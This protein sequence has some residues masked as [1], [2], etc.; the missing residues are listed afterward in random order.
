ETVLRGNK[1]PP[2]A[3]MFLI[4][5]YMLHQTFSKLFRDY[6][7]T[8]VV[9]T[10]DAFDRANGTELEEL[11]KIAIANSGQAAPEPQLR[12]WIDLQN[13]L[14]AL[15]GKIL[16]MTADTGGAEGEQMLSDARFNMYAYL[17]VTL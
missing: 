8:P 12:R 9:A 17:G 5:G 11:R 16:T 13:E 14:P 15:L 6:A 10:Y 1:V 3:F 2:D 7:P 4:R